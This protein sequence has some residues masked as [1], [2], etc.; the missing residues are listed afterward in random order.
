MTIEDIFRKKKVTFP[1]SF[2]YEKIVAHEIFTTA[3]LSFCCRKSGTLSIE[4]ENAQRTLDASPAALRRNFATA[5]G[6]LIMTMWADLTRVMRSRG[7]S[8][9]DAMRSWI[10][11]GRALSSVHKR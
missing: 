9:R 11:G 3:G 7:I 4:K 10:F 5:P 2:M 1:V 8:A 6:W